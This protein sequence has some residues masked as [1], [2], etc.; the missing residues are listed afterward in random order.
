M[1]K[2]QCLSARS[3]LWLSEILEV[4]KGLIIWVETFTLMHKMPL[5]L[6]IYY[7][8]SFDA[9]DNILLVKQ[10]LVTLDIKQQGQK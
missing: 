4:S 7:K 10:C 2:K 5:Y 9:K 1:I 3:L 8:I 6:L